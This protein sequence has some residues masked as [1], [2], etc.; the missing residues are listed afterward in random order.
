[1]GKISSILKAYTEKQ[2]GKAVKLEEAYYADPSSKLVIEGEEIMIQGDV[3]VAKDI[4]RTLK[5]P[6]KIILK[7]GSQENLS[8]YSKFLG[9]LKEDAV[10]DITSLEALVKNLEET[11]GKVVSKNG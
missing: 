11:Y 10:E 3:S 4:S 8:N 5:D 7:E 6:L 1:M 2:V 9:R